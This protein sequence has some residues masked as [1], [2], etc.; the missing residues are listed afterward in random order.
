M[1]INRTVKIGSAVILIFVAVAGILLLASS[2]ARAEP[3][4]LATYVCTPDYV[5]V[6]TNRVHVHCTVA[7][8]SIQWFAA[9]STG[10]GSAYASRVLSIFTT[11]KVTAK[12]VRLYYDPADT[13]GTACGCG[14]TDCRVVWGAEVMP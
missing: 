7:S 12:N 5:A 10:S 3:G 2:A 9:C 11:A 4:P 8:G 14:S 13:S 6:F 1:K